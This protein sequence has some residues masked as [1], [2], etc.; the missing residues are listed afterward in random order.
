M[1][2]PLDAEKRL[3]LQEERNEI[4][5][6]LLEVPRLQERLKQLR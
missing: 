3:A 4:E 2:G 6:A 5:A 1:F